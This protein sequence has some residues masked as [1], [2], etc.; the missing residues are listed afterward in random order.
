MAPKVDLPVKGKKVEK[1]HLP[2]HLKIVLENA[3][4]CD[5][6]CSIL[7]NYFVA[8][9]LFLE[10]LKTHLN[11]VPLHFWYFE[12]HEAIPRI[13]NRLFLEIG[14]QKVRQD[15]LDKCYSVISPENIKKYYSK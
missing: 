6:V 10:I 3:Q 2:E 13:A 4:N 9:E 15:I 1:P 14:N 11:K 5:T 7:S 8:D 12:N